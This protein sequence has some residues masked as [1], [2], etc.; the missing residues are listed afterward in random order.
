MIKNIEDEKQGVAPYQFAQALADSI[1]PHEM[2]EQNGE[3]LMEQ[4]AMAALSSAATGEET[5]IEITIE[6]KD[7]IPHGLRSKLVSESYDKLKA[8][9]ED[10]MVKAVLPTLIQKLKNDAAR[11]AIQSF[12]LSDMLRDIMEDEEGD[13]DDGDTK[14][15]QE[16]DAQAAH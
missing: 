7:G 11:S 16:Q 4:I 15:S 5:K 9:T 6:V 13:E 3:R 12:N 8:M 1:V 2:L 14:E 10:E